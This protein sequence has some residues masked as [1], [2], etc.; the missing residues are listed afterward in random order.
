MNTARRESLR[1]IAYG[2]KF[3]ETASAGEL[4]TRLIGLVS[5]KEAWDLIDEAKRI[6]M[7]ERVDMVL[8]PPTRN[9]QEWRLIK[10][11]NVERLEIPT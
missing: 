7:I 9:E 6:G 4:I 10:S 1:L 3:Y 8:E 11:F 2:L 5:E